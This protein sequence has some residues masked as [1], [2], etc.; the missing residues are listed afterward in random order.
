MHRPF[1]L[2][3]MWLW[4]P[5]GFLASWMIVYWSTFASL[6]P[7]YGTVFVG[8][9]VFAWSYAAVNG[10]FASRAQLTLAAAISLVYLGAWVYIQ[11]MGGWMLRL[12]PPASGS[13]SFGA[14]DIAES[15]AVLA[16][17]A[18]L[19]LL[20]NPVAKRQ[21]ERSMWLIVS[22]LA[23]YPLSYYG[24]FGGQKTPSIV[25][26]WD[27]LIAVGIGIVA[28]AWGVASGFDTDEMKAIIGAVETAAGT[29]PGLARLPAGPESGGQGTSA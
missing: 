20:S 9:P 15:V 28:F 19:W 14:Y 17:C 2:P 25:F 1:R 6:V 7:I 22:L 10:W 26:P 11:F 5:T 24:Q 21:V 3:W 13:W 29:Q 12:S 27:T 4:A 16:F 23:L 18:A 8:L